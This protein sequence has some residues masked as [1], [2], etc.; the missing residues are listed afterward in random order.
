MEGDDITR[1]RGVIARCNYLAAG[2]PDLVF[3]IKEGC[4]D[5]STDDRLPKATSPHRQI[6]TDAPKIRLEVCDARRK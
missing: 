3:D 2:R 1:Y 5:K 6:F 4:R